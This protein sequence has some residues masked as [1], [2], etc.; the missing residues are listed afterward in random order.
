MEWEQSKA[1]V[2]ASSNFRRRAAVRG[3]ALGVFPQRVTRTGR[4]AAAARTQSN[5]GLSDS[6]KWPGSSPHASARTPR[7]PR[8]PAPPPVRA[9]ASPPSVSLPSPRGQLSIPGGGEPKLGLEGTPGPQSFPPSAPAPHPAP[10]CTGDTTSEACAGAGHPPAQ[11]G[12]LG[13][14]GPRGPRGA[15]EQQQL[16]QEQGAQRATGGRGPQVG[17]PA[18][19][20]P[21]RPGPGLRGRRATSGERLPGAAP[22]T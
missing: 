21:H 4:A 15:D 19:G 18:G 3:Q 14:L 6:H 2:P 7:D 1:V 9:R 8:P 11:L 12:K 16:Q 5:P 10:L 17:A 20:G 13:A 22:G